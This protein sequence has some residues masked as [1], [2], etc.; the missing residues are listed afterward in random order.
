MTAAT[1]CDMID[2]R[3]EKKKK[4]K[5]KKKNLIGGVP[6]SIYVWRIEPA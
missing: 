6:L 1:I 4:K 5:K 2:E 3:T